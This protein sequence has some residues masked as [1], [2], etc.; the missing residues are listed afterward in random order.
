M[1]WVNSFPYLNILL[2]FYYTKKKTQSPFRGPQIGHD[3]SECA[4][5]ED[6]H[7][8]VLWTLS[9]LHSIHFILSLLL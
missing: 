3:H 5:A 4:S 1:K 9:I 8:L 2:A 7:Y 6:M